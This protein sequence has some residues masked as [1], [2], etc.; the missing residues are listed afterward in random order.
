M[1]VSSGS[2]SHPRHRFR[3]HP[4]RLLRP[5]DLPEPGEHQ[6][7]CATPGSVSSAPTDTLGRYLRDV[8]TRDTAR[9]DFRLFGPNETASTRPLRS[10]PPSP[11]WEGA[12]RLGAR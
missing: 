6:A 7:A 2:G 8:I 5:P 9:R 4:A 1:A 3:R 10:S 11:G 12:R